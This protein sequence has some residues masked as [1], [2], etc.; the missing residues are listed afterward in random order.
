MGDNFNLL[1]KNIDLS[2]RFGIYKKEFTTNLNYFID[3]NVL[4]YNF[5]YLNN[6]YFSMFKS[7]F[8]IIYKDINNLEDISNIK[9][10]YPNFSTQQK[11]LLRT[12]KE[13][14]SHN[15]NEKLKYISNGS[16]KKYDFNDNSKDLE[17]K[18]NLISL[19]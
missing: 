10:I 3:G 19:N 12:F 14:E 7:I 15:I 11:N 9:I 6:D 18:L 5:K 8:D 4:N 16:N 17:Q 13:S 1:V 2:V